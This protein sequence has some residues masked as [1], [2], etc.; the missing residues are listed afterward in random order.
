[1]IL[2]P[3]L[4]KIQHSDL[5]PRS[6]CLLISEP[7]LNEVYFQRAVILMVECE[8]TGGMGLVLNKP[9]DLLLNNLVEGLDKVEDIPVYCGGPVRR[10]RLFYLHTLGEVIPGSIQLG[11]N[12][13]IDGDFEL[14]LAYLRSG[15]QIEG[16]IR[17]FLGYAGWEYEQLLQEIE[18][19]AWI[20]AENKLE[21]ILQ[22]EGNQFWRESLLTLDR[23]YHQ[24][25]NY[26]QEPFL[27]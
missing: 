6:G 7:F 11:N 9:G 17:F 8:N 5:K 13:Y 25:L 26:P 14:I 24:W 16:R 1:M 22:S 20:V 21:S 18:E 12:L 4:F 10:D 2:K 15:N 19:D 3:N 27:N 23:R